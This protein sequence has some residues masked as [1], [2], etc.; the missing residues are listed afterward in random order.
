LMDI[1]LGEE[2]DGIQAAQKI[3]ELNLAPPLVYITAYS[4]ESIFTRAKFTLPFGYIL[5][6]FDSRELQIC[7]E[8]ALHKNMLEQEIVKKEHLLKSILKNTR[9]P[10][11]TTDYSGRISYFNTAAQNFFNEEDLSIFHLNEILLLEAEEIPPFELLLGSTRL[12][13]S[14]KGMKWKSQNRWVYAPENQMI[15]RLTDPE[16]QILGLMF[17]F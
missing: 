3:K 5:K 15:E 11:L 8:M 14:G 16:G 2:M 4:D 10:L 1:Q 17:I 9:T 7:I 13:G 12:H 6:P